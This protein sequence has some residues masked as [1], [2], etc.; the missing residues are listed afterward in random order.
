MPQNALLNNLLK[1][2]QLS[3]MSEKEFV[4]W[5]HGFLEISGATS[6]NE[7][8]LSIIKD[9]LNTFFIKVTPNREEEKAPDKEVTEMFKRLQKEFDEKSKKQPKVNPPWSVPIPS[10]PTHPLYPDFPIIDDKIICSDGTGDYQPNVTKTY[11]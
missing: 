11:C 3:N 9:H 2:N 7:K 10:Y 6:L 5:L 1:L 8:Q 4:I